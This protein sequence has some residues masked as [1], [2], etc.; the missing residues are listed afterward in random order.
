MANLTGA[1]SLLLIISLLACCVAMKTGVHMVSDISKL[2]QKDQYQ[3]ISD[4]LTE[5]L[6]E[7]ENPVENLELATRLAEETIDSFSQIMKLR[8]EQNKSAKMRVLL[9]LLDKKLLLKAL[10]NFLSLK[11][12]IGAESCN[13]KAIETVETVA[14]HVEASRAYPEGFDQQHEDS[15]VHRVD[16]IVA[17][18]REFALA[19]E[20]PFVHQLVFAKNYLL[21][22]AHLERAQV[23]LELRLRNGQKQSEAENRNDFFFGAKSPDTLFWNA[24][25][26]KALVEQAL[27]G[28]AQNATSSAQDREGQ[29]KAVHLFWLESC[30]HFVRQ[31]SNLLEE[32]LN[33]N[34]EPEPLPLGGGKMR[35]EMRDFYKS[36]AQYK[37]CKFLINLGAKGIV[38]EAQQVQN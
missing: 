37:V 5:K 12:L 32:A 7:N 23:A 28:S 38:E 30:E 29:A 21:V 36:L 8:R 26:A 19:P 18:F 25:I 14:L 22:K 24:P 27:I 11:S 34:L 15:I 4:W 16:K 6:P 2:V 1:S 31:T 17:R 3:V 20:C 10:K 13:P 33:L 35:P 9:D